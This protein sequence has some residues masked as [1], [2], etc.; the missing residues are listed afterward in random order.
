M[1]SQFSTIVKRV[2]PENK[3]YKVVIF[4]R[5][6]NS[7]VFDFNSEEDVN[8][9]CERICITKQLDHKDSSEQNVID[10]IFQSNIKSD[11][12]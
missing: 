2:D 7:E 3:I 11:L 10:S 1:D 9:F 8:K 6:K 12:I 4:H 5:H